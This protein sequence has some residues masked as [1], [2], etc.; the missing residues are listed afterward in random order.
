MK[1]KLISK[2]TT[3]TKVNRPVTPKSGNST[4]RC[5]CRSWYHHVLLFVGHLCF[6]PKSLA[7]LSM[8]S[9]SLM[10]SNDLFSEKKL[11]VMNEISGNKQTRRNTEMSEYCYYK[12]L[13]VYRHNYY[14][15]RLW[16]CHSIVSGRLRIEFRIIVW[17]V[18]S[19]YSQTF[20]FF[21]VIVFSSK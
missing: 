11:R 6:L 1:N 20:C 12:N 3:A 18:A 15:G 5:A 19:R 9:F 8:P 2:K 21:F 16:C 14:D 13:D 17:I 4:P 7:V 10:E